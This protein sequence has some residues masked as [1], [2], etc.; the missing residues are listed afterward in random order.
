[1]ISICL[2]VYNFDVTELTNEL[3]RQALDY[4]ID[5][6]ILIFDD[7][8][9]SYYKKI[10]S[11]IA[12]NSSV[13]YLEFEQNLGRSRIRN[14]LADFAKGKWLLFLDCDMIPDSSQFLKN[15]NNA[16]DEAN[17]ICGGISYGPK[18]FKREFLLRWKYGISRESRNAARRQ[19]NAY[20]S[21]MSGNFMIRKEVFN[22]IRFNE[23]ISGYGHEDTLFGLDLKKHKAS[24]HHINNPSIHLGIEPCFDY[25]SK[26]EHSIVNLVKL[27]E[28]V[29][30]QWNDLRKN[31]KLLK[32]YSFLR[33]FGLSYPLQWFFRVFNPII[34]KVLCSTN[35]SLFLF[36]LYKLGMLAQVFRMP[37]DQGLK[38]LSQ[39]KQ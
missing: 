29:P 32:Y 37:K 16:I 17:V 21:F 3:L 2:P 7:A 18:P 38:A 39:P 24:I 31:I 30:E 25:L 35:P 9:L 27:I 26:T 19:I 33:W 11:K 20:A 15:Y 14:R 4:N 23:R 5:I 36:D 34:R 1:M 8:S 28:I 10:N 12:V 22:Q 6:E 13:Q